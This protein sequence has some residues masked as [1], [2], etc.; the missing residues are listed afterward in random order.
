MKYTHIHTVSRLTHTQDKE[1]LKTCVAPLEEALP[2]HYN[3][4]LYLLPALPSPH[5]NTSYCMLDATSYNVFH[6]PQAKAVI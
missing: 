5:V 1:A 2:Q 4:Q 6:F 3:R